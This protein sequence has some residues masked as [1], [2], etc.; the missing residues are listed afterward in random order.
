MNRRD[1]I[2]LG[3]C[4]LAPACIL[5]AAAA[6][7]IDF[8]TNPHDRLAVSSYP[9][10]E[11]VPKQ[12]P[13]TAFPDLVVKRFGVHSIEPLD[14]HFQS[15]E[16]GYLKELRDAAHR[17]GVRIVN[18]PFSPKGSLCDPN[19]SKRL[20][21][22]ADAKRWIDAAVAI[23]SPSVRVHIES[24]GGAK[25][26]LDLTVKSFRDIVV[27]AQAKNIVANL[28]NDDP[29]SEDAFF[30]VKVIE[31]IDSPYLRA[32]PDFC[33]SMLI[34]DQAYDFKAMRAMF[35]H[36]YCISHVKDSEVD[37]GKVYRVDVDQTFNI[38]KASGYRGFYSMEWEGAGDP[39][40]GTRKLL[41]MSL[42]NLSA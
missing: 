33:N 15:R 10:R 13:L 38:A 23:G 29:R 24:A 21:S 12:I 28:E 20:E 37:N 34:G 35:A 8:P 25:P 18:L 14:E 6:P 32:L 2:K 16:P 40:E 22:V 7:H 9:F 31:A 3:A 41:D 11:F 39:Y 30:I 19:E 1:F 5:N 26:D 4:S 17:A 36:A 42:R 27:A